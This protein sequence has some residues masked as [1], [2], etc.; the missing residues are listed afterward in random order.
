MC[1]VTQGL[2]IRL[3]K[4]AP[5]AQLNPTQQSTTVYTK[6]A[7]TVCPESVLPE[8]SGIVP[9]TIIEYQLRSSFTSSMAKALLWHLRYQNSFYQK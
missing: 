7:S 1:F 2:Q 4:S 3:D 8:A 9:E 6:K 5:R